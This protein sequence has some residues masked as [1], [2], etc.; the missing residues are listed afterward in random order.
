MAQMHSI[1]TISDIVRE[2]LAYIDCGS[3]YK[4]AIFVCRFWRE[5]APEWGAAV[6]KYSNHLQTLVK[7]YP[8][9]QWNAT[10]LYRNPNADWN[11]IRNYCDKVSRFYSA[12]AAELNPRITEE[13]IRENLEYFL[14]I[15]NERLVRIE[16]DK[17]HRF[18]SQQADGKKCLASANSGGVRKKP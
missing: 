13:I 18:L 14:K 2:I 11:F 4:S 6:D 1:W 3:D 7:M 9:W 17:C 15:N 12:K 5:S 10:E 16:G 8:N